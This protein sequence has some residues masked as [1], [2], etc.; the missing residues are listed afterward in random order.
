MLDGEISSQLKTWA[1][2]AWLSLDILKKH[3]CD[4]LY[5]SVSPQAEKKNETT[6]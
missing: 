2:H 6:Q 3:Q 1:G 4:T 5:T